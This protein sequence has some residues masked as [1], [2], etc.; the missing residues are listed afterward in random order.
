MH[1]EGHVSRG[2]IGALMGVFRSGFKVVA[3]SGAVPGDFGQGLKYDSCGGHYKEFLIRVTGMTGMGVTRGASWPG[4]T[5]S[6]GR[7]H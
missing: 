2:L 4:V 5:G 1:R 3:A 6:Q 7:E